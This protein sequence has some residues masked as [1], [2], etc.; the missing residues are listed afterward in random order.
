MENRKDRR[1]PVQFRSSFSST[2]IVSG[3]GVLGDLSIRGCR[4]S[5]VTEV[6]PGTEV[7]LR[8]ETSNSSQESPLQIKQAV[9]RWSRDG[10]FGVEFLHLVPDQWVRLQQ[11]V[12]ELEME[13]F[14]REDEVDAPQ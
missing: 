11:K 14:K 10:K 3:V 12:R 2:N 8:I 13:P 4:V 7:E 1:F 5:S 6:K 9:V